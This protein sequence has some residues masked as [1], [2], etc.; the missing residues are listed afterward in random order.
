[1]KK[2][3]LTVVFASAL[4]LSMAACGNTTSSSKTTSSKVT[5]S[6]TT[7]SKA[8]DSSVT[9]SS[10]AASSSATSSTAAET[11]TPATTST[12]AETSTPAT[13]STAAETSTPATASTA[14][15]TSTPETASTAT[16][17]GSEAEDAYLY[18][19][20]KTTSPIVGL[21]KCT[22]PDTAPGYFSFY[23]NGKALFSYY[24]SGIA[25]YTYTLENNNLTLKD[26]EHNEEYTCAFDGTTMS[27]QHKASGNVN[28]YEAQGT[29]DNSIVGMWFHDMDEPYYYSFYD[30][31]R[32]V[33]YQPSLDKLVFF[34]YSLVGDHL[35]SE[36]EPADGW[37]PFSDTVTF[38]GMRA[39]FD[40][41]ESN[42]VED[43]VKV[44][45]FK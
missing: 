28:T 10:T 38:K 31:N 23:D 5:S 25:V 35:T 17:T 42:Q 16:E 33:M 11:S 32:G 30:D 41:D 34:T 24:G 12:A 39:F 1:M 2:K 37:R 21:W 45:N 8:A 44:L 14:A 19:T 13:A 36:L 3:L 20:A 26:E 15:E 4:V 27:L 9:D 7:S 18:E 29:V 22:T 43:V 6:A 40:H